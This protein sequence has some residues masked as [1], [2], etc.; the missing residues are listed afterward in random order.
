MNLTAFKWPF[1]YIW[2]MRFLGLS[3]FCAIIFTSCSTQV[4]QEQ[5][6]G[7]W[8]YIN[9]EN[10]NPQSE[11]ITTLAELKAARP[12]IVFSTKKELQIF[13]DGKIL[14]SGIYR[15]DGKMLRY[16]EDLSDG[17]KREF[18]FLVKSL[19]ENQLVFETMSSEVTRVTAR[20][21]R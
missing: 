4:D 16:T 13:W 12:Y 2:R 21:K 6:V 17:Q 19:S 5:L 10:M 11:D 20:K 14:S 3:F 15:I 1:Q 7:N 18:P 9:I 8:E